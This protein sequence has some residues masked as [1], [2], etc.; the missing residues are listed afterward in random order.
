MIS[1][2]S[3]IAGKLFLLTPTFPGGSPFSFLS[4]CWLFSVC[5]LSPHLSISQ[6][7]SVSLANWL[8]IVIP[9]SQGGKMANVLL[10][11]RAVIPLYWK[12]RWPSWLFRA[13]LATGAIGHLLRRNLVV[14]T[15]NRQWK[16]VVI[17]TTGCCRDEVLFCP[18]IC[19]PRVKRTGSGW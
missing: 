5:Y 10:E 12:L 18:D 3:Y 16:T 19:W 14:A 11:N 1:F 9:H 13:P 17:R 2:I 4:L 7:I 8:L 6:H 15:R